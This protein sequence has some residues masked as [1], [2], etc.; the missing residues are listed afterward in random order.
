MS[1]SNR[2]AKNR[3]AGFPG[4]RH[5]AASPAQPWLAEPKPR[6]ELR[7]R[8]GKERLR[9]LLGLELLIHFS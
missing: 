4:W 5:T 1:Q 6:K 2:Q 7:L 8:E 3:A 9:T